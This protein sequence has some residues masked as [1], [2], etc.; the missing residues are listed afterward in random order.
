MTPNMSIVDLVVTDVDLDAEL[1]ARYGLPLEALRRPIGSVGPVNRAR[2][3]AIVA[4]RAAGW[5]PRTVEHLWSCTRRV[6][7]DACADAR[8]AVEG[9]SIAHAADQRWRQRCGL[10]AAEHAGAVMVACT[11]CRQRWAQG[12]R[13]AST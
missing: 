9:V 8:I 11:Q 7:T 10:P 2:R 3:V 13:C 1:Q 12:H 6:L 5:P 4:T